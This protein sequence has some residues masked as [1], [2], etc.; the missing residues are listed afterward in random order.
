[1]VLGCSVSNDEPIIIYSIGYIILGNRGNRV[2]S[3]EW[4]YGLEQFTTKKPYEG[5]V[6]NTNPFLRVPLCAAALGGLV[7]KFFFLVGSHSIQ[8]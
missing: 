7:V 8:Y 3:M 1:M 4:I 5:G 2:H 6:R